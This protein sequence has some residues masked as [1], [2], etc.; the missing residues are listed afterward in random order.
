MDLE[1]IHSQGVPAI[2]LFPLGE[3]GELDC[4][5]NFKRGCR[6]WFRDLTAGDGSNSWV[7]LANFRV[8]MSQKDLYYL[9]RVI[10]K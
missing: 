8:K 9:A 6:N 3:R 4:A 2:L 10:R 7:I 5:I 1:R